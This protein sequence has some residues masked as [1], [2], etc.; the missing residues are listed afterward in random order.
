MCG[1]IAFIGE[2]SCFDHIYNGLL[3]LQNRGYDSAGICSIGRDGFVVSKYASVDVDAVAR[4]KADREAHVPNCVGLGHTRWLTHGNKTDENAHPHLDYKNRIALVHNGII[5]N[6]SKLKEELMASGVQ[7][8]SE[9]DSEVVVNLISVLYDKLGNLGDAIFAGIS[10]LEGSWAFAIISIERPECVYCASNGCP[11][12]VGSGINYMMLASEQSGFSNDIDKYFC[13]TNN[14]FVMLEKKG[15]T[16]VVHTEHNHEM[17]YI[18]RDKDIKNS[19]APYTHWTELEIKEQPQSSARTINL[20]NL[21]LDKNKILDANHLLLLGC[22]TSFFAGLHGANF[23]KDISAFDTVQVFDAGEF[24]ENDIPIFGKTIFILLSQSGETKDLHQCMDFAKRREIFMIGVVNVVDSMIARSV[25]CC[26]YCHAGREIAVASTKSFTS[27]VVLLSM[28]AVW[29]AENRNVNAERRNRYVEDLV[30]LPEDIQ[31]SI[32]SCEHMCKDVARFLVDKKSCFVLGKGWCE[33]IAKEGALKIKEIGYIHAE[34]YSAVALKH[35]PFSL[36]QP[37]TPVIFVNPSDEN[38][39]RVNNAMEEVRSRDTP[40]I[41]IT[42]LPP[43]EQKSYNY[44]IV[45]SRNSTFKGILHTIPMQLIAY[46]LAIYK[47]INP[48]MPRNLAKCITVN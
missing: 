34:G 8:R 4:L 33:S 40:I 19:P 42:D 22:G 10:R 2:T 1:I 39:T 36:L 27:Q 46:Y 30:K 3:M 25:N 14:D 37:D 41:L 23:F 6:Y 16:H 18:T 24:N 17:K 45:T 5:E 28:I 7:F 47:N 12:L 20:L 9:T 38:T 26:C 21:S 29:F 48:D 11:L 44:L 32:Y 15:G 43:L 35:G 31:G 13:L